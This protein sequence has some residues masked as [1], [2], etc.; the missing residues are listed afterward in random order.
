MRIPNCYKQK[1]VV[2]SFRHFL[3]AAL[4][5]L[6]ACPVSATDRSSVTLIHFKSELNV[7]CN[8]RLAGSAVAPPQELLE[9]CVKA[10]EVHG[11]DQDGGDYSPDVSDFTLP[12]RLDR[13]LWPWARKMTPSQCLPFQ[14]VMKK[15]VSNGRCLEYRQRVSVRGQLAI[16]GGWGLTLKD[17]IPGCILADPG[18]PRLWP[19]AN[20]LNGISLII[21][22]ADLAR[23][24]RRIG[25]QVVVSGWLEYRVHEDTDS[26]NLVDVKLL[27]SKVKPE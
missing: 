10:C 24:E 26:F 2:A 1:S 6:V 20:T 5:L 21:P 11:Y 12:P 9:W 22:K 15:P 3:G 17:P 4:L 16:Y 7:S 18:D 14:P 25:E 8:A 13:A 27:N 23:F 19:R